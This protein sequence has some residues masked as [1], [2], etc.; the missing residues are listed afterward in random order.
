MEDT[1]VFCPLLKKDIA[2]SYCYEIN[3][4]AFGICNPSL[5]DNAVDRKTAEPVCGKCKNMQM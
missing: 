1:L 2:D 5:I 4:V 3:S